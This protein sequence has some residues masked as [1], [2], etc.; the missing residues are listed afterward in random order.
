MREVWD[1]PEKE[2]LLNTGHEWLLD[3]LARSNEDTRARILMLVWRNWQLR[4]DA[5]HDKPNPPVEMTRRYLCSYMDSLMF[6]RQGDGRDIEK[7]KNVVGLQNHVQAKQQMVKCPPWPKPAA[8]WIAITVDGS[9]LQS[10]GSAGIGCIVRDHT[11]S[12]LMA[13]CKAYANLTEAYEAELLAVKEGLALSLP[14]LDAPLLLQS[15]S[16]AV[17]KTLKEEGLDRSPHTKIVMELK[18]VINGSRELVLMKVDRQQNRVAD[19]LATHARVGQINRV[20]SDCSPCFL[21]DFVAS[22]CNPI[23][24]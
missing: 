18:H 2:E 15:D 23:I 7:G 9:F 8:G 3:L 19:C 21:S 14:Y 24:E 5:V 1:L 13:A 22:D 10:D 17:L 12:V 16:A 20:W 4:N 6:L 11:G